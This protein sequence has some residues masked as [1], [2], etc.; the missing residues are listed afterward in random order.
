MLLSCLFSISNYIPFFSSCL[1]SLLRVVSC[2]WAFALLTML[3]CPPSRITL[4]S[5]DVTG[6]EHRLAARQPGRLNRPAASNVRLSPGPGR[7]TSLS[8]VPAEQ[9]VGRKRAASST[10]E[11]SIHDETGRRLDRGG[12]LP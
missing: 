9:N 7:Q 3:R 8:V 4:T 10:S 6:L 1:D 2:S 5:S 11:A 12:S